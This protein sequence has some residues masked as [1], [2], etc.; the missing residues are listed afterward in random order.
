MQVYKL[1][2]Y[3]AN[4]NGLKIEELPRLQVHDAAVDQRSGLAGT[5]GSFRRTVQLGSKSRAG[6]HAA[7]QH[8]GS[9]IR[10]GPGGIWRGP[11]SLPRPRPGK[12]IA[13]EEPTCLDNGIFFLFLPK[14]GTLEHLSPCLASSWVTWF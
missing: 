13:S 9:C 10:R 3:R 12:K 7:T 11:A 14:A 4:E 5:E 8:G 6:F 2:G 1:T